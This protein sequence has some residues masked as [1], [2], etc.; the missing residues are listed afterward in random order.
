MGVEELGVVT[1][2]TKKGM[3]TGAKKRQSFEG[4]ILH[5]VESAL[6]MGPF[7][8]VEFSELGP[9]GNMRRPGENARFKDQP[10]ELLE[11]T[12][13]RKSG[14]DARVDASIVL[15]DR[16]FDH[17]S[18]AYNDE[19]GLNPRFTSFAEWITDVLQPFVRDAIKA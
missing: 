13:K 2:K 15:S 12:D 9:R 4:H 17:K 18:G 6:F 11:R 7:C 1:R 3:V 19:Y 14:F 10:S 8:A 5:Q 16:G